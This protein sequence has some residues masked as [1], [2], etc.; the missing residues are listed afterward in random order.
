MAV[1]KKSSSENWEKASDS[2]R[3][4]KILFWGPPGSY[5]TREMLRLANKKDGE[6]ALAVVDP[7]YGTDHYAD[8][9]N[10]RRKQI[11][12]PDMIYDEVDKLVRNPGDII[13]LGF[14]SFSVYYEAL[15]SK[16]ADLFLKR[17]VS[18]KG[19]KGEYYTLQ[20]RDYQPINREAYKLVRLL[21]KADLNIIAICQTKEK[22]E[23]MKVV[24]TTF[25]GPKRMAHYFDTIIEVSEKLDATGRV[26]GFVGTIK[27][28]RSRK[29]KVGTQIPWDDDET[30]YKELV[31]AFGRDLSQGDA[32]KPFGSKE[33]PVTEKKPTEE[34]PTEE[35]PSEEMPAEE[36]PPLEESKKGAKEEEA[37]EKSKPP[38]T[39]ENKA[40]YFDKIIALKQELKI[41]DRSVWDDLLKPYKVPS[42]RE[43]DIDGLKA[44]I[45]KL[46][47]MRP[48][49][50]QAA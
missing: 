41:I 6:P 20:P 36:T 3:R 7:E 31:K 16:F 18:S 32:A 42:A 19:H 28:D 14:D 2:R 21:L 35:K 43:L 45:E 17:E 25:D 40:E 26:V 15:V 11:N 4:F 27:K 24:G 8:E 29:I 23:D 48:S 50:A 46:E 49:S 34:K 22:W 39:D 1:Q 10:F 12:D 47:S 44:F 30:I 13:T 37:K 5:K 33:Q 9:F 38:T